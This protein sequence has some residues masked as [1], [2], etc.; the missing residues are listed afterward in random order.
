MRAV[1]VESFGPPPRFGVR[2]IPSPPLQPGCVRIRVFAVGFGFPDALMMAGKYQG[3]SEP[4]STASRAVPQQSRRS[5][6]AARRA[7]S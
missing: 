6:R 5:R 2:E 1:V 3:K 7:R 4:N